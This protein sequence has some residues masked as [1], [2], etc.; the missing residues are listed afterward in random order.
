MKEKDLYKLK[1]AIER[2]INLLS[3]NIDYKILYAWQDYVIAVLDFLC[4]RY[5]GRISF[6]YRS[7]RID[8]ANL[9]PYEQMSSCIK[10][11]IEIYIDF[12]NY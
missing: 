9:E 5:G 6:D 3:K 1:D 10:K 7:Y 8:I 4:N 11:L 12:K 2:G